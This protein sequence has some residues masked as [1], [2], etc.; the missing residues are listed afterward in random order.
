MI[1]SD[2]LLSPTGVHQERPGPQ[3][4]VAGLG[5]GLAPGREPVRRPGE[6]GPLPQAPG[7]PEPAEPGTPAAAG[8]GAAPG[9]PRLARSGPGG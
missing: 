7:G 5:D 4:C 6:G 9:D 2:S 3:R 8:G 1:S